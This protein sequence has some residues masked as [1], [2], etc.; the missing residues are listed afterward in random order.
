MG[1]NFWK[2]A[3]YIIAGVI[4]IGIGVLIGEF[5]N[6]Q[7]DIAFRNDA[8]SLNIQNAELNRSSSNPSLVTKDSKPANV[9]TSTPKPPTTTVSN[10]ANID[11]QKNISPQTE[12]QTVGV[13]AALSEKLLRDKI[14][15][16]SKGRIKLVNFS[17]TNG[18]ELNIMGM[19]LYK[20]EYDGQIVFLEDCLWGNFRLIL[21]QGY[22]WKGDFNIYES[23]LPSIMGMPPPET[24]ETGIKGKTQDLKGNLLLEKTEKGWREATGL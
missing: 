12:T 5:N 21:G 15:N 14:Q 8:N 17:K 6:K 13:S 11:P 3:T 24:H 10:A 23:R 22:E 20:M 4:L 18:Q 2:Y 19:S 9:S 16:E 1:F 7:K